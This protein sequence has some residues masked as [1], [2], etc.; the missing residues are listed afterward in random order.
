M[1]ARNF[2]KRSV[3]VEEDDQDQDHQKRCGVVRCCFSPIHLSIA[4]WRE[5][6][7]LYMY[8]YEARFVPK[9]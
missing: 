6:L 1:K 9:E 2:R 8:V 4:K 7:K 3:E 5:G